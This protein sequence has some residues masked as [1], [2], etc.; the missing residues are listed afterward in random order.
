VEATAQECAFGFL[1]TEKLFGSTDSIQQWTH[2]P[3]RPWCVEPLAHEPGWKNLKVIYRAMEVL[4]KSPN[5]CFAFKI[6]L[7]CANKTSKTPSI[8]TLRIW[9][10]GGSHDAETIKHTFAPRPG[11]ELYLTVY[12]AKDNPASCDARTRPPSANAA[13]AE[14]SSVLNLWLRDCVTK[15]SSGCSFLSPGQQTPLPHRLLD[16]TGGNSLRLYEAR[17]RESREYYAL[18]CSWWGG[19]PFLSTTKTLADRLSGFQIDSLPAT[20][21]DAVRATQ[22]LGISYICVHALCIVQDPAEDKIR[23]IACMADIYRY[24]HLTIIVSPSG[25]SI[26]TNFC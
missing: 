25:W 16:F 26:F 20:I 10:V 2:P 4:E 19:Q 11:G 21:A 7:Q 1:F 9:Y 12:G 15:H 24:V 6:Q 22:K 14:S 8:D 13:S 3:R 18:S 17:K 5:D 23:E